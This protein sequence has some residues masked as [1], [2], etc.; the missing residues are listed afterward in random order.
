M[1]TFFFNLISQLNDFVFVILLLTSIRFCLHLLNSGSIP[2]NHFVSS[3]FLVSCFCPW[4]YL[5]LYLSLSDWKSETDYENRLQETMYPSLLSPLLSI[6]APFGTIFKSFLCLIIIIYIKKTTYIQQQKMER[7]PINSFYW[8]IKKVT[9]G[10]K[11]TEFI[12]E[13]SFWLTTKKAQVYK[14]VGHL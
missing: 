3:W 13:S 1:G 8:K 6:H 7:N 10:W 12:N 14:I 9:I 4:F 2:P 11:L 5:W